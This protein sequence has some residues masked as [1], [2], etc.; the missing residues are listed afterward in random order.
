M[1]RAPAA[2]LGFRDVRTEQT[3]RRSFATMELKL[4]SNERAEYL[5]PVPP[6][7]AWGTPLVQ[8]AMA[9]VMAQSDQAKERARLAFELARDGIAHSFDT[10]SRTITIYTEDV[11]ARKEGICFAKSHLLASLLRGMGIP[12]GFCYQRVLRKPDD[13]QSGHALHGLNA[14]YLEGPG[15]F[16][17]DPRGNKPGVDSQFTIDHEQLAYPIRPELGEV[18]YPDLFPEPLPE[19]IQAMQGAADCQALFLERPE[20][21]P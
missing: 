8:K 1:A 14:V 20:A 3:A 5:K 16:R 9:E 2:A 6:V 10:K 4:R 7:I 12:A 19:V 17:V 13:P 11:L 18:D 21:L 15:W